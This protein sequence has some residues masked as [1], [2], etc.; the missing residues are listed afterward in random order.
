MREI[1][2][3]T[4]L[5]G[6]AGAAAALAGATVLPLVDPPPVRAGRDLDVAPSQ[7]VDKVVRT[8]F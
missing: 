8:N 7:P 3:R 6:A 5:K 2:R 4:V 1:D